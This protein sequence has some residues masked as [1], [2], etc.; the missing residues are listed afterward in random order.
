M[1]AYHGVES[2][3]IWLSGICRTSDHALA[4]QHTLSCSPEHWLF[5]FGVGVWIL[6]L[7]SSRVVHWKCTTHHMRG[8]LMYHDSFFLRVETGRNQALQI[9]DCFPWV[10]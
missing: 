8:F 7:F 6:V 3:G 10:S 4:G 2:N 1:N 5:L 9:N